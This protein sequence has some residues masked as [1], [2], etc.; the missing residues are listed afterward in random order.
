MR[1]S[2]ARA[3]FAPITIRMKFRSVT[4]PVC[5]SE[6]RITSTSSHPLAP[7]GFIAEAPPLFRFFRQF[8]P[9]VIVATEVGV[10]EL[11]AM[12]KRESRAQFYLAALELMDFNR[13]WVQ[14]EVD[15]YSV[16]HPDLGAELVSAGA[17]ASKVVVTG[18]PIDPAYAHVPDRSTVQARLGIRSDLPLLLVLFGGTGHGKPRQIAAEL[19]RIR[20]PFQVVFISG[21]NKK[22]EQQLRQICAGRPE[23]RVLGWVNNMHDWMVAGDLLLSKPG[24]ATV[25]EAAACGLPL[26]ALD[27]LPGNEERTCV[28]LEKWRVG[29]WLRSPGEIHSTVE[30]VLNDRGELAQLA[31]RSRSLSRPYA[32]AELARTILALGIRNRALGA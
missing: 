20:A 8:N 10:C 9:D 16:V 24:G 23:W 26:L 19:K 29:I 6:L 13:A 3:G 2:I 7:V 1:S 17:P 28:W 12:F 32:A 21:R 11:T 14:A 30:R 18:M 25:M 22:M 31:E 27:P 5:G 15:L 4:G